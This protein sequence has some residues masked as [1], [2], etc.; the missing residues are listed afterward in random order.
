MS[1][2]ETPNNESSVANSPGM[3][4][5]QGHGSTLGSGKEPNPIFVHK[6][7]S[8]VPGAQGMGGGGGGHSTLG[9]P[10]T[11]RDPVFVVYTYPFVPPTPEKKNIDPT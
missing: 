1:E 6:I 2:K 11:D 9:G 5:D 10:P 7:F 4:G 3:G 8:F